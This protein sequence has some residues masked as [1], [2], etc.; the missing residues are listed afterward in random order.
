[1]IV[2][3]DAGTSVV[4]AVAFDGGGGVLAVAARPTRTRVPAP[5]RAEQDLEEVVAAAGEVIR[6]VAT[7]AGGPPGLLGVTGQGDGLWLL[8]AAGQAVRPAILWSDAR[9]AG[10]V[11][12]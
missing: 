3:F 12:E 5:G 7:A 2:G 11:A 6:E 4:K 1:V 8:D 10:I 9:A